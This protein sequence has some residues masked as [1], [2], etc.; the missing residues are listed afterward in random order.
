[1][2][3]SRPLPVLR[4]NRLCRP[5][6]SFAWLDHPLRS[7]GFLSRIAS[8]EIALYGFLTLAADARGLS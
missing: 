1:M 5:P 6:R 4:A 2:P 8:D 3:T 7:G